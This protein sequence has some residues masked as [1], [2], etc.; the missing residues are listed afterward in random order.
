MA[1][2]SIPRIEGILQYYT[3]ALGANYNAYRNHVY[4]VYHLTLLLIKKEI[5]QTTQEQ[6]AIAA[7][8][9]DLGIWTHNSMDYLGPSSDLSD[10]YIKENA[11]N[12]EVSVRQIIDHHH[13]LSPYKG[14]NAQIVESFRK[15]DLIDL[16]SGYIKFGLPAS[17]YQNLKDEFPFLGFHRLIYGKVIKHAI[18]HFW[19]P[20]PMMK[21]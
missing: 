14:E 4:R 19:K 9:H 2:K 7:S 10:Q 20:F 15:A 16:S 18:S 17:F 5:D 6:L 21:K 13:K 8:F 11:M 1:N 12:N 3:K